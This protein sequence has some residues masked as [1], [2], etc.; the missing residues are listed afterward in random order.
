M[1]SN[2][3][4]AL[5]AALAAFIFAGC[6]LYKP[7][8]GT[9]PAEE[10][11]A[12]VTDTTAAQTA[13]TTDTA[14]PQTETTAAPAEDYAALLGEMTAGADTKL[15]LSEDFFRWLEK[16]TRDTALLGNMYAEITKGGFSDKRFTELS[17]LTVHAAH[18][19][20]TGVAEAADNI[21]V[22]DGDGK[23]G[24]SMTF[25]G[26]ISFADNWH[27]MEYMKTTEH[28]L[29]D[30]ISAFL[31]SKM[32]TAD[33]ATLNNEFC[34]SD[35]GDPLPGKMWTFRAA[36]KNVKYYDELGIDI[37]DL[38]NNHCYDYG[39]VAFIDTLETL[40]R[41]GLPY[42]GAGRN[43][44]EASK[45][46]YFIVE[47]KKIAFVAATRAEKYVLTPEATDLTPGVLRCYEPDAFI[48][49][50]REAKE[51]ADFV[52][53]NLHWG[54]EDSHDLEYE[55][56][57]TARL[58]IDAGADLIVGAHAHCLQ[59]VEFYKHVPII[60]NLGNFWF[61]EY[62][63]DTGLLGVTLKEDNSLDLVF[64]P[65]TQR[66][67]KTTYVGGEAEG[68]RILRNMR[69]YSLNADFDKD[70]VITETQTAN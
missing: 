57:S 69:S 60:Y 33:I 45:P 2:R 26:D 24:I 42:M 15:P 67:C 22:L 32:Q 58:Y 41:A 17:G 6:G 68:E 31:M 44:K 36:T 59:G 35:R 13:L 9:E 3:K 28:G 50:I 25:G 14:A 1:K 47:G 65:A 27:V 49:V 30:C 8:G 11:T 7:V 46:Q 10:T 54:T 19:L 12:P 39:E 16:Y 70:G 18:D 63:I 38:A 48:E 52:I 4:A 64:Y 40:E 56:T 5:A 34:F 55:Q 21:H 53:A 43:I 29:G 62:D 66:D 23:A 51:N 61:S 20:Y 37:V